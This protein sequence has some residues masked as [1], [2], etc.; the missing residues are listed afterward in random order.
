[1]AFTYKNV[2]YG[3][4]MATHPQSPTAITDSPVG[5]AVFFLDH[6]WRRYE[7][8]ARSFDGIPEGITRDDVL[9]NIILFWLTNMGIS[10]GRLYWEYKGSYFDV[11]NVSIPVPVSVFPDEIY[12]ISRS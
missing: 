2:G 5:L 7:V 3:I 4:M 9:D 12:Y 11:K 1:L 10:T 6:D 8:I